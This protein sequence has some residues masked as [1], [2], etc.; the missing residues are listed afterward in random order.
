MLHREPEDGSLFRRLDREPLS[1]EHPV[2]RLLVRAHLGR[3]EVVLVLRRHANCGGDRA[4]LLLRST[5]D[6]DRAMAQAPPRDSFTFFFEGPHTLRGLADADL[7][8]RAVELLTTAS[9]QDEGIALVPIE[10]NKLYPAMFFATTPARVEQWF[11]EHRGSDVVVTLHDFWEPNDAYR[12]TAYVPDADGVV[13]P[14][15]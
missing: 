6:L 3:G 1:S 7:C 10:P 8:G 15:A 14:G 5:Q 13:R 11:A 4:S 9:S 2:L 12:V